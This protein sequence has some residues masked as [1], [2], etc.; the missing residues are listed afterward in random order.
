MVSPWYLSISK[1]Y[2]NKL[3]IRLIKNN[4][5]VKIFMKVN[6]LNIKE[7]KMEKRKTFLFLDDDAFHPEKIRHMRYYYPLIGA[8]EILE[9]ARTGPIALSRG[10]IPVKNM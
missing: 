10:I 7:E 5:K 1:L 2:K 8:D 9:I 6:K 3:T 4:N